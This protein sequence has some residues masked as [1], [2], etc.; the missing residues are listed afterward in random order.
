M[1]VV[2][3]AVKKKCIVV[4]IIIQQGMNIHEVHA[5]VATGLRIGP[6]HFL[7]VDS[8]AT[9]SRIEV[10]FTCHKKQLKG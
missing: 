8:V 10:T 6:S 4:C 3:I 9:G 7:S 5:C 1:F 2:G